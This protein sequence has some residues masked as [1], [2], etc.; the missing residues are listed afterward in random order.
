M[1]HIGSPLT[2]G[3][4]RKSPP[5][6]PPSLPVVSRATESPADSA[7]AN[8]ELSGT[9]VTAV[10]VVPTTTTSIKDAVEQP[11]L[12]SPSTTSSM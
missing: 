6:T 11:S 12:P 5:A 7:T 4:Q 8:K 1:S 2:I 9:S 3:F 10:V